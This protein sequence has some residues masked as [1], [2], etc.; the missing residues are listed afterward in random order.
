MG[1]TSNLRE[2]LLRLVLEDP[3]EARRVLRAE[4]DHDPKAVEDFLKSISGPGDTR[5]RHL[6]ANVA[7]SLENK[8]LLIKSLLA[9]RDQET[10]EFTRRSLRAALAGVDES[11]IMTRG[12]PAGQASPD[13]PETYAYVADRLK[14]RLRNSLLSAQSQ[15]IALHGLLNGATAA[16]S[17]VI[18]ALNESMKIMARD[19]NA[20]DVDPDYFRERQIHVADWLKGMNATYATTYSPIG[21]EVSG[22]LGSTI[23][24]SD[25]LLGLIFWNIWIDAHQ[26][27]GAGCNI[28]VHIECNEKNTLLTVCD[29]GDG[30]PEKMMDIAFQERFSTKSRNRGRGLLEVQDAVAKLRGSI[31]LFE[32]QPGDRRILLTLPLYK[33]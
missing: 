14:H 12:T 32:R 22:A 1:G 21:L 33:T 17:N 27:I 24:G 15:V 2:T 31:G 28:S 3:R 5:L 20:I 30:F 11:S 9:W 25:Y 4:I 7:R 29:N 6:V 16:Q 8:D 23:W 18:A 19:L 26:I 13:L 10:D